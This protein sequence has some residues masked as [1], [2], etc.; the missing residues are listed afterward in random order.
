[1]NSDLS[2]EQKMPAEQ[3]RRLQ[4]ARCGYGRLR[5]LID[6]GTLWDEHLRG[7]ADEVLRNRITDRVVGMA[8]EM[9]MDKDVH[10][11]QLT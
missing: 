1:M 2:N 5:P 9:R 7:G 10:F 4:A 8:G 6:A 11:D 3:E